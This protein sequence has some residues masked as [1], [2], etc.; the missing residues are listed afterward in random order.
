M[1]SSKFQ[2][3]LGLIVETAA[4]GWSAPSMACPDGIL[5]DKDQAKYRMRM[6]QQ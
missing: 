6:V 4:A 5:G 2:L 3:M 1:A